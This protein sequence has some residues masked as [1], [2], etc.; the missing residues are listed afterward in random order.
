MEKV[1]WEQVPHVVGS[2]LIMT[3]I[4]VIL[5]ALHKAV[6]PLSMILR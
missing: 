2:L 3:L 4:F 6:E 5:Q 1:I